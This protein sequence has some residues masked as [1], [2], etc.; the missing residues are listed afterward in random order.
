MA[1][2]IETKL[3]V[4]NLLGGEHI[5]NICHALSWAKCIVCEICDNAEKIE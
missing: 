2:S 3:D 1:I 5:V 4:I